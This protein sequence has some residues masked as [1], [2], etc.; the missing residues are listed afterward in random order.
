MKRLAAITL[1]FFIVLTPTTAFSQAKPEQ[2]KA[3]VTTPRALKISD[4]KDWQRVGQFTLSPDAKWKAFVVQPGEGD[5]TLTIAKLNAGKKSEAKKPANAKADSAKKAKDKYELTV[6][7]GSGRIA[8]SKDSRFV[9][10]IEAPKYLAAK[11]ARKARKP[12]KSKAVLMDLKTGQRREFEGA[13]GMSFSGENSKCFAVHKSRPSGRPSG[14][15]GWAG[16]DLLVLNLVNNKMVNIGNVKSYRF[17]KPGTHLAMLIDAEGKMANGLQLLLTD[18]FQILPME[19]DKAEFKSLNWN[20]DGDALTMLKAI[21]DKSFEN[22]KHEL[23]AYSGIGS[24]SPK[25]IRLDAT[26]IAEIPEDMTITSNRQPTW[27][28]DRSAILFGIN[29]LNKKEG[30]KSGGKTGGAKKGSGKSSTERKAS[31]KPA[32]D[33]EQA[34]VV[35]WHWK[36]KRM[37]S[38]QQKQAARDKNRNDLC[39]YH[40]NNKQVFRLGDSEIPSVSASKPFK[41]AI[42]SDNRKYELMGN[43]DG[44]R[45]RDIYAID[46]KTNKRKLILEKARFSFGIA[47]SGIHYLYYE[48]G[49]FYICNL[50]NGQKKNITKSVAVSFVNTE[51]DHN[52]IKPP[53]R[54]VGWS[55]DGQHV[56]LTDGFDI[57][58]VALDGSGGTNLTVDGQK[59]QIRYSRPSIFDPDQ[60]GVD[61][62]KPVYIRAYGEWTKKAGFGRLNPGKP[63]VEMLVWDNASFGSLR[64]VKDH[65]VYMFSKATQQKSSNMFVAG[66][67]LKDAKQ[68]TDINQQQKNFKWSAGVKLINYTSDNGDKLQGALY[69]PAGYIEGKK[70]PT[71]VYMYE[72]LSQRANS[73]DTPRHGGFSASIYTSNGYAVF[74]PDIVFRVNDPGLSSKDCI[75]AGLKAAVE[76]GIVD[77]DNVGLHGHSWGGY[78]TAFLITQTDKFKAAVA[79]APLTNMISMYSSIY[80][81][82]GSANQPIFESSQGR[83]TGGY[84][85]N[86]EAY[87]RNSPVYYADKVKTPLLLLHNDQDGAVDWNQ[88]IEYFNTLRRLQKPVVMLQYRGENH[89]LRKVPNR[90][91]YSYRMKEFFDHYLKSKEAPKW[92]SEGIKH[93]D[94]KKHIK[95]Y[96]RKKQSSGK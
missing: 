66:P 3:K 24:P 13:S 47:P 2:K 93:L 65:D 49:H 61:F 96:K 33:G 34:D 8:F 42:G 69:L 91:D 85:T 22:P 88:G 92:W 28:T 82:T 17:N 40:V 58:K 37:Q 95:D 5:A 35:I 32:D 76:T 71:I 54:P 16:T 70:Y 14:D 45:Y 25:R 77:P 56:L 48:D 78:Q 4:A 21:K 11:A 68:H 59:K 51:D 23:I 46:L 73:Y 36:D 60:V 9:A 89:G 87:T 80:F 18:N 94:M 75:L 20:K 27:T 30:A 62:S 10:F 74:N 6:G 1:L 55:Q 29:R 43:L 53:R 15:A 86:I 64:K 44:R 38:A 7:P 57:W 19:N 67:Q 52:V 72:K 83:F 41:Y 81:N 90:K 79:G 84:W 12:L 50:V 26:Q 39:I 63:G 31:A